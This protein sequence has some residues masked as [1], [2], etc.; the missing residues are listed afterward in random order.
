MSGIS[1]G[2]LAT[3]M[4]GAMFIVAVK[5]TCKRLCERVKCDNCHG[6]GQCFINFLDGCVRHPDFN[7][8]RDDSN[9]AVG[10]VE[11]KCLARAK[12]YFEWCGNNPTQQIIATFIP[13]GSQ[14]VFPPDEEVEEAIIQE[15]TQDPAG[16]KSEE[17]KEKAKAERNESRFLCRKIDWTLP[18]RQKLISESSRLHESD[19]WKKE[20]LGIELEG[21]VYE[22]AQGVRKEQESKLQ[23]RLVPK[24]LKAIKA[25]VDKYKPSNVFII[26]FSPS[27]SDQARLLQWLDD[28]GFFGSTSCVSDVGHVWLL[29]S[30]ARVNQLLPV[31]LSCQAKEVVETLKLT[32]LL[33]TSSKLAE[34]LSAD[35]HIDVFLFGHADKSQGKEVN[36][37][38]EK[39]EKIPS[40]HLVD[41]DEPK[42]GRQ[43][44]GNSSSGTDSKKAAG[45]EDTTIFFDRYE[46]RRS[47]RMHDRLPGVSATL[48]SGEIRRADKST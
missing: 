8:L 9:I 16:E 30:R 11:G 46:E 38:E 13:T 35:M 43:E 21:I 1:R 18:D 40:I 17:A 42:A 15:E 24:A 23:A 47:R 12:D 31:S 48:L 45:E 19:K 37:G 33:S 10:E 41:W 34:A 6:N 5:G 39:E 36:Q 22:V 26:G 25:L 4:L 44:Q 28:V 20:R 29:D 32:S 2:W 14:H 3:W 7:G 27:S